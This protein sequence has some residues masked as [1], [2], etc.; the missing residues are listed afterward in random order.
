M[1]PF[2]LN[3]KYRETAASFQLL[4]RGT[5]VH[6]K[7]DSVHSCYSNIYERDLRMA[8]QKSVY[9]F[10]ACRIFGFRA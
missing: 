5:G 4:F 3:N 2:W 10:R 6:V 7:Y 1:S 9:R 8:T